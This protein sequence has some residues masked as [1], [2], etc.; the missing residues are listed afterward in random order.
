[1]K[2]EES[3]ENDLQEYFNQKEAFRIVIHKNKVLDHETTLFISP[4]KEEIVVKGA[5]SSKQA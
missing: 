5:K 3:K 2:I 4:Q 1:M